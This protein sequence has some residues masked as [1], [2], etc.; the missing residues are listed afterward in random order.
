MCVCV[1]VYEMGVFRCIHVV[2][3]LS[4]L[5]NRNAGTLADICR[6]YNESKEWCVSENREETMLMYINAFLQEHCSFLK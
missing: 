6:N 5:S 3:D 4:L 1:C 2:F